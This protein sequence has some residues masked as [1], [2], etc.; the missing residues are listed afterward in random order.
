MLNWIKRL[1]WFPLFVS[2]WLLLAITTALAEHDP[3]FEL[4]AAADLNRIRSAIIYTDRGDMY[5]DLFP[6]DA[7][8][9]VANFKYLADKGFY[10]NTHFHIYYPNYII[11]G[12]DPSGNGSGGPGYSLPPEF[13]S[14]QHE[15]GILGM[16][17]PPDMGNTQRRSSGSQF[18]ILLGRAAQ[19]DGQYTAFGKIIKG[20]KVLQSL[21]K[22]D[23]IR[24]IKVFI[25]PPSR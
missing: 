5:F 1:V 11:Q 14:H 20:L 4:P 21:R 8:W 10:R 9:H 18:H 19:M 16:A 24:D 22:G 15:L 13:N 3:P 25:Q 17:R 2:F 7:P 6:E 23:K 12:G